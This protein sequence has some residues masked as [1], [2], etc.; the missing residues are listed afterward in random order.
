MKVKEL[1][2][3]LKDLDQELVVVVTCTD[4]FGYAS[5]DIATEVYETTDRMGSGDKVVRIY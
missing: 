2:E 5:P 3:K 1:I 4:L